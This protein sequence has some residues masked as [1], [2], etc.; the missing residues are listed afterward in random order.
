MMTKALSTVL[1]LAGFFG[2]AHAKTDYYKLLSIK[3]SATAREIKSACGRLSLEY[4]P[5]KLA[6]E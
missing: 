3:E 2:A 5:D 1:L 6:N 4:H